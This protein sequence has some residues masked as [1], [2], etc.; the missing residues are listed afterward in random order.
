MG[1]RCQVELRNLTYDLTTGYTASLVVRSSVDRTTKLHSA[2]VSVRS[3]TERT[4]L[5]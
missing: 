5:P 3:K 2:I 4:Y 1:F